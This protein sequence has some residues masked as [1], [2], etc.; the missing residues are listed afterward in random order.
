MSI[1]LETPPCEALDCSMRKSCA[2]QFTACKA[3]A[4]FV[5]SGED[6]Y[7]DPSLKDRMVNPNRQTYLRLFPTDK[8]RLR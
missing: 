2:E 5:R 8:E 7:K 1:E 3:F 6:V 4:D